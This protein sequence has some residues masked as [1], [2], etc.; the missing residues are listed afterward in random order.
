MRFVGD[1]SEIDLAHPDGAAEAEFGAWRW[2]L[3]RNVPQLVVPF[4]RAVYERVA[5]RIR[6]SR[7]IMT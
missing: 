3:L 6:P 7:K 5:R 2:E 1:D 4:K